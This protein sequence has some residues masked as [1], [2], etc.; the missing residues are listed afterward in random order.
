MRVFIAFNVSILLA[1]FI[2]WWTSINGF[3]EVPGIKLSD[4][5][6]YFMLVTL[7]A[8]MGAILV[9][10]PLYILLKQFGLLNYITIVLTASIFTSLFI[11]YLG[12]HQI[13]GFLNSAFLGAM[14]S[15][16][17]W[18]IYSCCKGG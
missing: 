18:L 13:L 1:S 4:P 8:Y 6:G 11:G 12:D 17:F 14:S 16:C 7:F 2:Y 3:G 9:C 10:I 5:S 15:T